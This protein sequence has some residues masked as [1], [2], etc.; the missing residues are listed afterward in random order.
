[1]FIKTSCKHI[2]TKPLNEE[3]DPI[4]VWMTFLFKYQT[5]K[6]SIFRVK[7]NF[8]NIALMPV[9]VHADLFETMFCFFFLFFFCINMAPQHSNKFQ[10][11]SRQSYHHFTEMPS[12]N[13]DIS[14]LTVLYT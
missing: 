3:V 11:E 9:C 6:G 13:R 14:I 2:E 4:F 10:A 7:N 5:Q 1:M 12:V 8:F